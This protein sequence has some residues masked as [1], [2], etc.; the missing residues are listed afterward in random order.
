M[1]RV[2]AEDPAALRPSHDIQVVQAVAM[3]GADRMIA[4]QDQHHI[5]IFDKHGFIEA[6][7]VGIDALKAETMT[8]SF[9]FAA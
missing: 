6:A 8:I 7:A 9:W 5:A 1:L 4:A 3:R 2:I